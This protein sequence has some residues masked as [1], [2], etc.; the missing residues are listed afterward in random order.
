VVLFT[1]AA[2]GDIITAGERGSIYCKS[3]GFLVAAGGVYLPVWVLL[4][5]L[6]MAG[7]DNAAAAMQWP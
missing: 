3:S 4:L 2:G 6:K 7:N 5:L 1:A